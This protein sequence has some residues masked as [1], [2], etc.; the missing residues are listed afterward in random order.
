MTHVRFAGARRPT[1]VKAQR[2]RQTVSPAR[3]AALN[4]RPV[5]VLRARRL[6]AVHVQP[7]SRIRDTG[8]RLPLGIELV[9]VLLLFAGALL[10]V[11][12]VLPVLLEFAAAPF[13]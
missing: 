4:A 8:D 13:R 11:L 6:S 12:V 3:L 5:R 1:R 9:R 2:R 7:R 10:A